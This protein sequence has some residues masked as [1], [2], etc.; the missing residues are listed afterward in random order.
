MPELVSLLLATHGVNDFLN[1]LAQVAARSLPTPM[2]CGITMSRGSGPHTVASSDAVAESVDENQ[3]GEG[4]GP[5]L[6]ALRTGTVVAAPDLIAERRWAGYP[7]YA[8]ACGVRSSLS[9]PLVSEGQTVG[10][11]NLYAGQTHA[12]D[13]ESVLPQATALA[14]QGS[15]VLSV[16]LRQAR[17]TELTEQLREALASRSVIDQAIGIVMGQQRC[18][19]ATAFAVLRSASQNRNRKLRDV[20]VDVVTSASGRPPAPS[21][22]SEPA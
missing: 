16:A 19:S 20:A 2:S 8:V 17:Q 22:F 3:Y 15:A 6:E 18:D 11:L 14:A 12:F 9:L 5:C 4:T 7:A 1:N 13:G 10:A 21:P